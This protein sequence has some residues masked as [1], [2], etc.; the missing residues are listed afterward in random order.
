MTSRTVSHRVSVIMNDLE[1]LRRLTAEERVR[2]SSELHHIF[3]AIRRE[4]VVIRKAGMDKEDLLVD[5]YLKNIRPA[6]ILE[7][8]PRRFYSEIKGGH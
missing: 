5:A 4:A 6:D 1:Q 2:Y 3:E 8:K 7:D